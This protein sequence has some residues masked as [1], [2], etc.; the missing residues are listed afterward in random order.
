[1]CVCVVSFGLVL[2]IVSLIKSS[3]PTLTIKRIYNNL[4]CVPQRQE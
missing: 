3:L 2:I 4:G 1:V